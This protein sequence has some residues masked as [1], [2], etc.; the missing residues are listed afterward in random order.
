LLGSY[1]PSLSSFAGGGL[2]GALKSAYL[3][4][5][6]LAAEGCY[7]SFSACSVVSFIFIL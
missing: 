5:G 7:F 6:F 1:S 3:L 4:K 2:S